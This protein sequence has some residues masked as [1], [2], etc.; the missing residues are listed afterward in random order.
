MD[1]LAPL[2]CGTCRTCCLGDTILLMPGDDPASYK[3]KMTP[4]GRALAKGK[5]GNC[6]YLTSKGCGIHGRAPRM[7]REFDCRKYALEVSRRSPEAQRAAMAHP[8]I[9][10]TVEEGRKRLGLAQA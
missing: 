6:V 9:E 2:N 4:S 1:R 8:R 7:C 5:G 10:R 3:T